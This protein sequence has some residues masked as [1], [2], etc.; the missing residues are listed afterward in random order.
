MSFSTLLNWLLNIVGLW[1]YYLLFGRTLMNCLLKLKQLKGDTVCLKLLLACLKFVDCQ[2]H[3]C[4]LLAVRKTILKLL[5]RTQNLRSIH[6]LVN[7]NHC[8]MLIQ[9]QMEMEG[10]THQVLIAWLMI[11]LADCARQSRELD[12]AFYFFYLCLWNFWGLELLTE[13]DCIRD[14]ISH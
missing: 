10:H 8:C 11:E 12:L 5:P 9:I 7:Y 13:L 3:L 14:T 1:W 4:I 6:I 2:L